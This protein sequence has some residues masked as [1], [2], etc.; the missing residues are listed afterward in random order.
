MKKTCST[1]LQTA[2]IYSP[3]ALALGASLLLTQAAFAQ[4]APASTP[5]PEVEEIVVVGLRAS[6]EKSLEQKRESN[7]IVDVITAEDVGKFPDKNVADALQRVP[8]VVIERDGGEGAR[9]SIRGLSSDLTLTQ[10]NGNF[11]ASIESVDGLNGSSNDPSRSFNYLMLPSSLIG[12]VEAYKSSEAKLDDG[13]VGGTIILRTRR[14]L[15]L[16]SW[17]GFLSAEGTDSDVTRELEPQFA[18]QLSWRNEG[19]TLGVLAGVSSQKR[20]NRRLG[21][22]TESWRWWT[23]DA[24]AQP[25]TDTNGNVITP[26]TSNFRGVTDGANVRYGGF[27]APTAVFGSIRNEERERLGAQLTA[28]W[29]PADDLLLTA[30]YFRFELNNDYQTYEVGIPEWMLTQGDFDDG[31]G[32]NCCAGER[33]NGLVTNGLTFDSTGSIVTG[34][35]FALDPDGTGPRQPAT[36]FQYPQIRGVFSRQKTIS[37]TYDLQAEYNRDNFSLSLKGGFTEA[38]GGPKE[39]FRTA[40]Y[41]FDFPYADPDSNASTAAS[42]NL[43][44]RQ[45]NFSDDMIDR[46][47]AGIGGANDNGSTFSDYFGSE[48][49]ERYVQA[50][51]ELKLDGSFLQSIDAGVKYRDGSIV[52]Q[53]FTDNYYLPGTT[54]R[55]QDAGGAPPGSVAILDHSVGNLTGGFGANVFPGIDWAA[56]RGYLKDQYGDPVHTEEQDF[57]YDIREQLLAGYVQANYKWNNIRGNVGV[58]VVSTQQSGVSPSRITYYLDFVRVRG[59]IT[60]ILPLDQQERVVNVALPQDKS[61]VDVLPSFNLTWEPRSD[62]L[63]R[64]AAAKVISRPGYNSIGA[65]QELSFFTDEYVGDRTGLVR[66][67]W[68]GGGGNRDLDPFQAWQYD[69]GLEWYFAPGAVAGLTLFHKDVSSFIVPLV[70]PATRT[71]PGLSTD[72]VTIP[73]GEV[74]VQ[75]YSTV[76][77]GT[78][79]RSQGVEVFGQYQFSWGLGF[80]GNFT[81]NDTNVAEVSLDGESV[82]K[83][84]LVG[85]AKTQINASVF[86]ES[87]ALLLRA[88]YNRRGERVGGL[89]SGFTQYTRPYQQIDLNAAYNFTP[90]FNVSASVINLTQEE[91]IDQLGNDTSDRLVSDI[92]TGRRFYLGLSY[93]F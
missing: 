61:Y 13:G 36:L 50:D 17:S 53:R 39:Q 49:E 44:T 82:G 2:R 32:G 41:N 66:P 43:D 62:L 19:E 24:A 16:E 10:L 38:S 28:Q 29:K 12:S 52:R 72:T 89:V 30:N 47:H 15:D 77:N 84:P 65:A 21:L 20:T 48:I 8:G 78:D 3:W 22:F 67:G 26:G 31:I 34:A 79:A 64:L 57:R 71:V 90:N 25:P 42:W 11:I 69:L 88:S 6:L 14:P 68:F 18:G 87:E 7:T 4:D 35:Q 54:T 93:K 75:E 70:I 59:D 73:G 46:L 5:Q 74:T 23:D 91:E 81:Y 40:Y 37:K 33:R 86:Y 76:A 51:G 58:R 45:L 85:S 55:Y 27:W 63:L 83:S 9:V 60:T 80:F 92:Y 56:F 1:R